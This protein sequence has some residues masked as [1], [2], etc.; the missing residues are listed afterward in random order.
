MDCHILKYALISLLAS[1]LF[2]GLPITDRVGRADEPRPTSN[3]AK[4]TSA[5]RNGAG[6]GPLVGPWERYSKNPILPKAGEKIKVGMCPG[7]DS[8]IHYDGRLWMFIYNQ[9]GH[10]TKLAVS[11]DGLKWDY[12]HDKPIFDSDQPWEGSYALTKAVEVIDGKVHLYYVGKGQ[13]RERIGIV[14]NDDP[15]LLTTGWTKH[16]DNPVFTAEDLGIGA[17]AVFPDTVIEDQGT[18]YL[19]ADSKAYP[20]YPGGHT[21]NVASSKDGV[22]FKIL[23]ADILTPGSAGSWNSQS[24]SQAAVRKIGDWWYMIYSGYPQ[25]GGKSAQTFGLARARQPQG[26]W[27]EYPENPIFTAT[28]NKEDWDGEFLQ[29]ACPVQVNGEWRLY[30][31]GNDLNPRTNTYRIGVAMRVTAEQ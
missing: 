5:A 6:W 4:H 16:A 12:V 20:A 27:E 19:F 14:T 31:S 3:A 9:D 13:G 1:G 30:Y 28:G 17:K 11:D 7:P 26:P 10:N 8:I 2:L 25:K 23:A 21:I 22:H 29:H 24:V 15:N 18:Y